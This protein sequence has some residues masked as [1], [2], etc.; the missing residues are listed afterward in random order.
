MAV[1]IKASGG[2][3][4]SFEAGVPVALFDAPAMVSNNAIHMTSQRREPFPDRP[5]Q[6]REAHRRP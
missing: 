5:Q 3:K 4:P 2:P 6:A 1:S